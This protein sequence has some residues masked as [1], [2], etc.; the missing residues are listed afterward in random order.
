MPYK[1]T[2]LNRLLYSGE[3]KCISK[4]DVVCRDG[5]RFIGGVRGEVLT[6][7]VDDLSIVFNIEFIKE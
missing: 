1:D 5:E 2:L 4:D 6:D 7:N 3:V